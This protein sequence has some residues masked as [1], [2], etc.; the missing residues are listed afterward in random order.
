MLALFVFGTADGVWISESFFIRVRYADGV[1]EN[2]SGQN[3]GEETD[4]PASLSGVID[5]LLE[6]TDGQDKVSLDCVFQAFSGRLYGPLML[7]PSLALLTPLGGIPLMPIAIAIVLVLVAG[8]RVLGLEEP[9]VPRRMR[10]KEIDREK[11]VG[12]FKKIRPVAKF[13]DTLIRPRLAV[14]VQGPMERVIALAIVLVGLSVPVFGLVPLAAMIPGAA[15]VL[16]SLAVTARD[17][18]LVLL[19][20]A[21]I[22][23][24][25]YAMNGWM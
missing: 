15:A 8:Q 19:A 7:L 21:V 6:K 22:G 18:V 1:T 9:W 25:A 23:G 4:S 16:L 10:E 11:M 14:L 24:G 17:G 13:V 3:D 5:R 2:N 12:A 20:A